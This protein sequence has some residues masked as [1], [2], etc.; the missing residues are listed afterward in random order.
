M[1]GGRDGRVGATSGQGE[2]KSTLVTDNARSVAAT[3][4]CD[5]NPPRVG[6]SCKETFTVRDQADASPWFPGVS[7]ERYLSETCCRGFRGLDERSS[8]SNNMHSFGSQH[9]REHNS[10]SGM[11][12]TG[13]DPR[14]GS[15]CIYIGSHAAMHYR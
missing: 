8:H 12:T 9:C 4:G 13:R 14:E 5:P 15:L 10:A 1:S 11:E 2:G 7:L 6:S 3:D